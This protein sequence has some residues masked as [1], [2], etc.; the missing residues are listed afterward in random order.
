MRVDASG[1][2]EDLFTE[3]QLAALG[4]AVAL[5]W[6]VRRTRVSELEAFWEPLFRD[7]STIQICIGQP[8]RLGS[9]S[10]GLRETGVTRTCNSC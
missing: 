10:V 4:V 8:T 9:P 3:E 5:V 7:R 2:A 1:A 6:S